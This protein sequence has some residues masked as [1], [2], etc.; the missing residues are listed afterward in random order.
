MIPQWLQEFARGRNVV[1]ALLLSFGFS[2]LLFQF[3]S[4]RL[5]QAANANQPLL[6]ERFGYTTEQVKRQF[7]SLG[8]WRERYRNFQILDYINA[9]L[10]AL[11]LTLGLTFTFTR[12]FRPGNPLR[13]LVYL[14]MITAIG[15]FV[16][17]TM[18][19]VLLSSYPDLSPTVVGIA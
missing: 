1:F 13:S 3:T 11:A 14:P 18:L 10:M 8:D 4:Y 5:L 19:I 2:V 7:Q 16:E 15:E 17:N 12:L 9:I 6:E